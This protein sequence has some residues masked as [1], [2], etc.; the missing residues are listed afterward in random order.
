MA[1]RS[2]AVLSSGVLG[3][4]CQQLR[5]LRANLHEDD[6]IHILAADDADSPPLGID[7]EPPTAKTRVVQ[8]RECCE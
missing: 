3:A 7:D 1:N 6:L 5:D 2:W 8:V 4:G